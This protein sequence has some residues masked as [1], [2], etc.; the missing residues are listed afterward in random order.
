MT[1]RI[2]FP[3]KI[4]GF[5]LLEVLVALVIVGTVLGASLRAVASL[6]QNSSGLR[7]TM[8][9]SWSAENRLAQI[10]LGKEWPEI[11]ERSFPCPQGELN[12]LCEEHVLSTPNPSFRRV[13]VLVFDASNLQRR[14]AKLTQVVPNAPQ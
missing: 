11:G 6:A 1:K 12:L 8:M 14:L 2:N 7:A 3:K 5:T 9:A 13:E 4:D 10:R